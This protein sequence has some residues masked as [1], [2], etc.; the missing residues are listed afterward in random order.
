MP[1]S[2]ND[3]QAQLFATPCSRTRLVTRFGVSVL[4]VVATI[5]TPMSHQGAARPEVKNSA[6]L[7]PARRMRRSAGTNDTTIDSTTMNQSRV[8]RRMRELQVPVD[9]RQGTAKIEGPARWCEA[10]EMQVCGVE[11]LGALQVLPGVRIDAHPLA[12]ADEFR[13]LHRDAVAQRGRLAAGGLG[14]GL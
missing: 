8:V 5:E 3:H 11:L 2:R 7:D 13:H 10:L 12:G 14:R 4:K 6:V 1:V 9:G